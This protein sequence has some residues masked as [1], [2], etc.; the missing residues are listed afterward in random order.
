MLFKTP[1]PKTCFPDSF[2]CTN[3][4]SV[5][6]PCICTF[7]SFLLRLLYFAGENEMIPVL[8][9]G[10]TVPWRGAFWENVAMSPVTAVWRH[11]CL[12]TTERINE[13]FFFGW[14]K[15]INEHEQS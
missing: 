4:H 11:K 15:N 5:T 10:L 12:G 14:Q 7:C 9:E 6:H 3:T 2:R 13:N 1:F 8:L